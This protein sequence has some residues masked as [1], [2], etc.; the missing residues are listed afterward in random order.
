MMAERWKEPAAGALAG[1]LQGTIMHP[2][3]TLRARLD[4]GV[5]AQAVSQPTLVPLPRCEPFMLA[6]FDCMHPCMMRMGDHSIL[7]ASMV[8]YTPL[9]ATRETFAPMLA[10]IIAL[11]WSLLRQ[12][13]QSVVFSR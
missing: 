10:T 6:Y 1:L 7:S 11:C 12:H 5:G 13:W 4:M 8:W 9:Q 2:A 3:D